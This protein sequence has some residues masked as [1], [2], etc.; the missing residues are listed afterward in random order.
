MQ[1][2]KIWLKTTLNSKYYSQSDDLIGV[3]H[4]LYMIM[5]VFAIWTQNK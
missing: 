3:G 4:H 2:M 1:K 5:V